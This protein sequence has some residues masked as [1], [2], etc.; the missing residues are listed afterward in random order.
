[1]FFASGPPRE[2]TVEGDGLLAFE[3]LTAA[4][5]R[6]PLQMCVRVLFS[7]PVFIT[8]T[9]CLCRPDSQL[10]SFGFSP[11]TVLEALAAIEHFD[12]QD[13]SRIEPN[14]PG[15]HVISNV[16]AVSLYLLRQVATLSLLRKS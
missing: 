11:T 12:A 7:S 14:D 16:R 10:P 5:T 2:R 3:A 8:D 15:S 9:W 1:M 4:L 13:I 6:T